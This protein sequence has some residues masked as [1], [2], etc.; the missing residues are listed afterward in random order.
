MVRRYV[1]KRIH[2]NMGRPKKHK[3]SGRP[4]K[5]QDSFIEIAKS[6]AQLGHT[7]QEIADKLKISRSIYYSWQDTFPKFSDAIRAGRA[8]NRQWRDD[9]G[10]RSAEW[11]GYDCAH[12]ADCGSELSGS[13]RGLLAWRSAGHVQYHAIRH[14][15]VESA[16]Q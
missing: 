8:A 1:P 2:P 11:Y 3:P 9:S 13:L 12:G 6:L 4:S 15:D 16:I 7:D 5:W 14:A 10:H